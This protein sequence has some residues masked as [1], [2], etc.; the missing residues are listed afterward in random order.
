MFNY[1]ATGVQV[2]T[3]YELLP[4]AWYPFEI[5]STEELRSKSGHPMVLAKC[6]CLDPQYL[7]SK[8][9]W[10]YITFFDQ[11][12]KAAG[13]A[14]HFLKSIGMPH[15]G[16][17]NVDSRDWRGKRFKGKVTINSYVDKN[18]E[19]RTNNKITAVASLTE[20]P[21]AVEEESPFDND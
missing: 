17:F 11:K 3:Q 18:G 15:E 19:K 1:D 21:E 16:P 7:H 14:I 2:S 10:H 4:E 20:K 5:T 12:H 13:I 8:E 6:R 9:L